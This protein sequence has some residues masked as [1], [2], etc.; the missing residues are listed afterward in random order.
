MKI[1]RKNLNFLKFKLITC[2]MSSSHITTPDNFNGGDIDFSDVKTNSY[3]GKVVYINKNGGKLRFQTP[4]MFI[5]Y[6]LSENEITDQKTNEVIGHKYHLNL[7]FKGIDAISDDAKITKEVTKLKSFHKM[8]SDFDNLVIKQAMSSSLPWLKMKKPNEDTVK[9]LFSPSLIVSK[10]KE[11][12]EP[13]G[14]Y[15]DT[16]KGKI[17]YWDGVFQTEIY[18]SKKELV[19]LKKSLVKGATGKALM[20]CTGIWFAGGRF[21]IGWKLVQM[22]VKVPQTLSG[23]SFIDTS[24]DEDDDPVNE[25]QP[26]TNDENLDDSDDDAEDDDDDEDEDIPP[27]PKLK[28]KGKK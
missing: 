4:E 27:P 28:L 23:Y 22:K 12:Q 15:P 11:T 3:G 5:P 6:G 17:P 26:E 25:T 8:M 9:A 21:G 7:S 16:I 1:I 13:N 14:K 24:D 10:D 20:E 18:N 19:D 2:I